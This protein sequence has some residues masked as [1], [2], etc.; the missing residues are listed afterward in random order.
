MVL[1]LLIEVRQALT[2]SCVVWQGLVKTDKVN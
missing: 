1:D 2:Q